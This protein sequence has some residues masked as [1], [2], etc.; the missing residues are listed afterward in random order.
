MART[1]VPTG[2]TNAPAPGAVGGAFS[3]ARLDVSADMFGG[4][5]A[6]ALGDLGSVMQQGGQVIAQQVVQDKIIENETEATTANN[7]YQEEASRL[8]GEFS[9]LQGQEA[10]D[11]LPRFQE[12]M[13]ALRDRYVGGA[14]NPA[15]RRQLSRSIGGAAAG[16][17]GQAEQ[18]NGRNVRTAGDAAQQ[19]AG[20]NAINEGVRQRDNPQEVAG[21]LA[22][23]LASVEQ[24]GR[25]LGWDN[26]TL[27]SNR[28]EFRGR[29]YSAVI[30]TTAEND[31]L[32]AQQIF[33][34]NRD[35]M[36]AQSQ[37]R[38]ENFLR[39]PVRT[40]RAADIVTEVTRIPGA[41]PPGTPPAPGSPLNRQ[42]GVP[43]APAPDA[44]AG[45][46]PPDPVR[47]QARRAEGGTNPDGTPRRN[48][49]GSSAS[50]PLQI[51]DGTWAAYARRL[52]LTD[53]QRNDPEAHNRVWD[54]YQLDARREI[55]RDLTPRE[56]YTAWVLGIAG[57]KAFI[58]ADPNADAQQIFRGVAG[59]NI[60]DQAFR[61]N[62]ALLR[63]GITV[64]QAL[65]NIGNYFDRHGGG[66]NPQGVPQRGRDEQLRTALERAGPDPELRAAVLSQLRQQWGVDDAMNAAERSR[67]DHR[68]EQLGRALAMGT[69]A[70]IPEA[71]IRRLYQPEQAAQI[72]DT[73]ATRQ[74]EGD[75]FRSV[76]LATPQQIAEMQAGLASGSGPVVQQLRERRGTV[77]NA[78]GTVSEADVAGDAVARAAIGETFRRA[79]EARG[80]ALDADPAQYAQADP[81]VRAAAQAQR[82]N[83]SDPALMSAYA[84]ATL[85][86]QA[87]LGVPEQNRRILSVQN[88]AAL[89][90]QI[91]RAD[92]G[93][94]NGG[95]GVQLNGLKRLYGAEWP[96]VFGELVRNGLPAEFQVLANIPTE[97]ARADFQRALYGMRQ[98]GGIQQYSQ[99]VPDR[100]RQ[101]ID[102]DIDT[103]L[104]AFRTSVFAG[105]QVGAS[106]VYSTYRD[107]VRLMA[108]Y[109]SLN[110][111]DGATA[112]QTAVDR[113]L[114]DKYEFSGTARVPRTL[115]DGT[116]VG[117][118]R[119]QQS[120][121]Y[122][123][124]N[125]K[126]DDLVTPDSRD[127]AL[128]PEQRRQNM[129]SVAQ[130]GVWVPN[131]DDSGLVLMG[132]WEGGS[133][134][135]VTRRDGS[136]IEIRFDN[137]PS[138][139]TNIPGT[140]PRIGS[141]G[142]RGVSRIEGWDEEGPQPPVTSNDAPLPTPP[143]PP[144]GN[145]APVEHSPV[146]PQRTVPGTREPRVSG[147]PTHQG[148]WVAPGVQ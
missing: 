57:A 127:P 13:R 71:D 4:S 119:V 56:Q 15:V 129:W 63:P 16:M 98:R 93:A 7:T 69:T 39:A 111:M 31:P 122:T 72:L 65:Q 88:A 132:Q 94:E 86:A 130:R 44:P 29:F 123:M 117:M 76:Q 51:T 33:E 137:L 148:R 3:P 64:A 19:A 66:G 116:P 102:R 46:A 113:V 52:G 77:M 112:V 1:P 139:P 81:A 128:S 34:A 6:R 125:L 92:P 20:N 85:D 79:V 96:R 24:R 58:M 32:R 27:E 95:M 115:N 145:R 61:Q 49:A 5:T 25:L 146:D 80:S 11:A 90:G 140:H 74:I 100:E 37:I 41:S 126:P 138:A 21:S 67:M 75:V 124:R 89:A 60:A 62:G 135:P 53:A 18:L 118:S 78:D 8:W 40:R 70:A 82:E 59:P 109:Y 97:A 55:G 144:P 105:Q 43:N 83:P 120:I 142:Q 147:R 14:T 45:A 110:G 50:G 12:N 133:R 73:L 2:P 35:N 10:V 101:T 9:N 143:I 114:N 36:D 103:R 47:E 54:A 121:S 99:A 108:M 87:R 104:E 48:L 26:A 131:A 106:A 38:I 42:G 23:G 22:R 107:G 91:A 28:A 134:N 84:Q 17:L 30:A 68:V 136:V 141:V